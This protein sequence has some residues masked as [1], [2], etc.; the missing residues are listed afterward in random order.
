[1]GPRPTAGRSECAA[2]APGRLARRTDGDAAISIYG[3]ALW[4]N[5]LDRRHPTLFSG[6]PVDGGAR[7]HL[8][9]RGAEGRRY[10]NL[11]LDQR[12]GNTSTNTVKPG[13]NWPAS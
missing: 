4:R 3:M 6:Q 9:R 13:G 1:M 8:V 2:G 7:Q 11:R 10:A 12:R 5:D